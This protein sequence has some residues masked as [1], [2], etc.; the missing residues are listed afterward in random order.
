MGQARAPGEGQGK[1]EQSRHAGSPC[2]A[3]ENQAW[4]PISQLDLDSAVA[5]VLFLVVKSWKGSQGYIVF[6]NSSKPDG[7]RVLPAAGG[8]QETHTF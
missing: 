8:T 2:L 1:W 7:A 6:P 4:V 3:L 5:T